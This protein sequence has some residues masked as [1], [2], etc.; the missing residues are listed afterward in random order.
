MGDLGRFGFLASARGF[1][2]MFTGGVFAHLYVAV[3]CEWADSRRVRYEFGQYVFGFD[4]SLWR[5]GAFGSHEDNSRLQL[6]DQYS[7]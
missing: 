5:S 3:G 1:G 2:A 7:V 6:D 4:A